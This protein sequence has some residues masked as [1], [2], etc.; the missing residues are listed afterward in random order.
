[1]LFCLTFVFVVIFMGLG[2]G[3][4]ILGFCFGVWNQSFKGGL[5]LGIEV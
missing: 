4:I 5:G 1:M 3:F 2:L